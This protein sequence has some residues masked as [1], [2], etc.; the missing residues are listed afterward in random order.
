MYQVVK[1]DGRIAEFEISKISQAIMKAFDALEKQY[2][3]SVIDMLALRVMSGDVDS[4]CD[5][6]SLMLEMDYECASFRALIKRAKKIMRRRVIVFRSGR[7]RNSMF[8]RRLWMNRNAT[9]NR[10]NT[11]A[12]SDM[13]LLTMP[14]P[15]TAEA[16]Y[17]S[18]WQRGMASGAV[19]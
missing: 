7:E 16:A 8:M 1:R 18:L 13:M 6:M 15:P 12:V 11:S 3:P 19:A 5:I 14:V 2:H 17:C 4:N 10:S 9:S